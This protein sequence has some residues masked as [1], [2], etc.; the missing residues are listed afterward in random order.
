MNY[1]NDDSTIQRVVREYFN[2]D[3]IISINKFGSGLINDTFIVEF[4]EIKYILQ[5]INDYVFQSPIGVMY[6]IEL[7]TEHIR[8]RVIYEGE[9]YRNATL[10]LVKSKLNK[11]FVIVDDEYWRCYT[12]IDGKTYDSTTDPEIFYEAGKAVG[13]FQRLLEGFH[14]RFL[15]DNIKNF[16]NTPYRYETFRDVV[17]IDDVNRVEFCQNEIEFIN[18][19]SKLM[20]IITDALHE[21]RIPRRVVHNDTKLNNIIFS[22]DGKTALCLI[23]L[24]TAMKGSLVYDY[25]DALR[26]GA[27]TAAEDEVDLSKVFINFDLVRSFTKGF[28]ETMKGVIEKEE[29]KLLLTGYYTMTLE[30]GMRFLT[31]YLDGDQYFALS[32]YQ[33]RNRPNINLERARNQLKL[34]EEIEKNYDLLNQIILE[35]LKELEYEDIEDFYE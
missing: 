17:K 24:D 5:K 9:N 28:L 2:P 14:T 6:N 11:N 21:K 8:N 12:W 31:D 18:K 22:K 3:K 16:H 26:L 32:T 27:S 25:G 10:T 19:R 20:S 29:I 35:T 34:V 4:A 33:K 15:T 7:I 13:R 1:I 30:L 23:D